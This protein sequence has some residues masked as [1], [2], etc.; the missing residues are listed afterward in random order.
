MGGE[1]P[2]SKK[3]I[4]FYR[5]NRVC[6]SREVVFHCRSLWEISTCDDEIMDA[7]A[8]AEI[9]VNI[10]TVNIGFYGKQVANRDGPLPGT[11]LDFNNAFG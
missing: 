2:G 5:R 9:H 11:F 7:G 3:E 4:C 10:V 6:E 8:S 1:Q